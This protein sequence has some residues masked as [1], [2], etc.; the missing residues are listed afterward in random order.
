MPAFQMARHWIY[1]KGKLKPSSSSQLVQTRQPQLW[2]Q[3]CECYTRTQI[4][5]PR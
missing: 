5:S 4:Y 1:S 3:F 2:A